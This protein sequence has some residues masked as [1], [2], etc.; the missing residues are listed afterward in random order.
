MLFDDTPEYTP[1]ELNAEVREM[2]EDS[3]ANIRVVGELSN[4]RQFPSGH[5][6][7]TLKDADAQIGGACFKYDAARLQFELEDGMKVVA[8]GRVTI[9]DKNGKYQLIARTIEQA[10]RGE[11][12]RAFAKLKEKLEAEGLFDDAHKKEL[13]AY[14]FRIG[15]V[16]SPTGAA[17]RDIVATIHRRWP[18]A[19]IL[20]YPVRVQGD[21]A[22]G[23]IAHAI[24]RMADV[25]DLDLVIVGR[26]GGS[27]E[28]LWAFNEEVV[29]RAIFACPLPVVSAVGHET[30]FTIAD[31]VADKR[32]ATPTMAGEVVVPDVQG[33]A[34]DLSEYL[35]RTLLA[36]ERRI[37]TDRH[38]VEKVVG[39]YAL[40]KVRGQIEGYM[41]QCDYL[42]ERLARSLPKT[43]ADRAQRLE[44][45]R[46]RLAPAIR[47]QLRDG[48]T[49]NERAVTRL[50]PA[51]RSRLVLES[52]RV[53]ELTSKLQALD[54][55]SVLE[56]G[57]SMCSHLETGALIKDVKG[58]LEAGAMQVAFSDGRVETE[59]KER[60]H[61]Q[62]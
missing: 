22:A 31:Y 29:A 27:L 18:P 55:R 10:G 14:P 13:P 28:D 7:F 20:L 41:Q 37:Q 33:I 44:H 39:S 48:R 40:G 45:M 60:V 9:Y 42:M 16:T 19:E 3:Y 47:V 51:F 56:R 6:Y 54:A 5:V 50:H 15:V 43:V 12:E 30:D 49:R 46:R 38:R 59:V 57:F 36:T 17:I 24:E 58:A 53:R 1:T 35:Q 4:V 11:L 23:E 8:Q 52:G 2:L 61:E 21:L 25:V 26:G 34:A 62:G 32:A